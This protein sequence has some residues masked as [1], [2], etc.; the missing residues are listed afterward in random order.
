[1][2][3]YMDMPLSE[4]KKEYKEVCK[5]VFPFLKSFM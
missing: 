2:S 5:Y 3:L 1:M 4:L